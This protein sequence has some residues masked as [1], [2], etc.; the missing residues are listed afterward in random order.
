MV[1]YEDEASKF[2]KHHYRSSWHNQGVMT[3]E[4]D[5]IRKQEGW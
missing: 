3:R 4:I 5:V 2:F 1:W